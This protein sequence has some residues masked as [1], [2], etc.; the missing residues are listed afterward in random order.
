[1]A[2]EGDRPEDH[3]ALLNAVRHGDILLFNCWY[4]NTGAEKVKRL[5]ADAAADEK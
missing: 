3:S 5:Y 2:P 4:A 1:M